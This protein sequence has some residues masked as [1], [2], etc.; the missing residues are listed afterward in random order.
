MKSRFLIVSIILIVSGL[1]MFVM[2]PYIIELEHMFDESND[3]PLPQ[4]LALVNA[5]SV[6]VAMP[7]LLVGGASFVVIWWKMDVS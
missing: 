5:F 6:F 2:S 4:N 1:I 3:R 7:I